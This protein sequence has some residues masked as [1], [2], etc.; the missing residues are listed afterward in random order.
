MT[1][2]KT[3]I[4][5]KAIL[6]KLSHEDGERRYANNIEGLCIR[7][8]KTK[9]TYY[10]HWSI[11]AIRKDGY[12]RRV[13]KRKKLGGYHLPLEEIK[14]LLR[15]SIDDL[16]KTSRT[17]AEGLTVG[18]LV[19]TFIKHGIDGER[20]RSRGKRLNYKSTTS[21]GYR[22]VLTRYVLLK[23]KKSIELKKKMEEPVR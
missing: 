11:P 4:F 16:K 18:G 7:V 5:K 8:L 13:G 3:I 10:A 15:R 19:S 22:Q 20:V 9:K 21:Q 6:Y 23:G 12:I 2:E 14:I 17:E 1:I